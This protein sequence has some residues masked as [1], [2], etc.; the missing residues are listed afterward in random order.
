MVGGQE[1]TNNSSL[2]GEQSI[3]VLPAAG[4]EQTPPICWQISLAPAGT[5]AEA[6]VIELCGDV[7]IGV[8]IDAAFGIDV[9][10]EGWNGSACEVS[11]RH[12]LLRPTQSK[13]F[14][15]D[16]RSGSGTSVN[17]LPLGVGWAYALQDRDL[18][19]LGRLSIH[20]RIVQHP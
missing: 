17:G 18:I 16:M 14:L 6:I 15:M 20:F 11:P 12:A 19:T 9:D 3:R 2:D 7:V 5:A 4:T 1:I 10:L 13:V 8:G